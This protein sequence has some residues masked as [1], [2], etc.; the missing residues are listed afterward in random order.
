ME[1]ALEVDEASIKEQATGT[2]S[3]TGKKSSGVSK[4]YIW[5][6]F[7]FGKLSVKI[8]SYESDKAY[9]ALESLM[10]DWKP[11]RCSLEP[12]A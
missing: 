1:L 2:P 9:K 3:K 4:V 10:H 12:S 7:P 11:S 5:E 6:S 8:T